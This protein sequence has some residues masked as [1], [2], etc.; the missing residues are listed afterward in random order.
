[1]GLMIRQN[2]WDEV[3]GHLA[4]VFTAMR[5]AQRLDFRSFEQYCEERLGMGERT[6]AQRVALERRLHELP[7]LR[8]AMRDRRISHEKAMDRPSRAD[9]LHRAP[10]RDRGRSRGA[11]V[12]P[13]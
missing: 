12:R 5:G 13:A 4:L 11:A 10:A 7:A 3:F 6:V 2:G 1:R 9:A 8:Q